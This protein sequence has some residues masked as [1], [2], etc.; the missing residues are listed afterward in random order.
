MLKLR[1]VC[2]YYKAGKNKKAILTDITLDFRDRE[3]V[4]ILGSSGSGKST[5]L[6][7][8]G[9]SLKCDSGEVYLDGDCIS[10]YSDKELDNYRCNV[11]GNIFQDYNLIEYM[12]VWD[13][14]MLGY[15]HG[16]TKYEIDSLLKRLGIY[17]YKHTLV[18]KLSGGEKQ[19]VAI[20][21]AL[22]N[23]PD[24]ILADEPTGAL[25]SVNSTE[26]MEILKS[27]ANKKLVIV[28]S[29]DN[30]LASKYASRI[31]KIKDG[32]CIYEEIPG[33]HMIISNF[34][35]KKNNFKSV[36][37]LS[38]KNLWLKKA[39]TLF[40]SIAISLG[41]ISMSLVVILY[42]NFNKEINDLERSI[43]KVFPITVTNQEYINSDIKEVKSNDK[44]IIK[45]KNKQVY[46][47]KISNKYIDY[48][49]EIK[50]IKYLSYDYDI[51]MPL[52]SD[53]YKFID[54]KYIKII[55][56]ID[57]IYD[58]YIMLAGR[59]ILDKYEILLK[60]DSNNNVSSELLNY[61][62]INSDI[63]YKSIL[64][65]K[66]KVIIN[67]D[68]Y[69]KNNDYY[70]TSDDNNLMYSKSN[71]ELS[72]V[73]IIREK[74]ETDNNN[75]I[76]LDSELIN[77][78]IDINRE[79]NIVK[80]ALLSSHSILG[81]NISNSELL[82]YLGYNTLPRSINI[83]VDN[84]LDK[85]KV[86]NKL[87][88]YNK[89]YNKMIYIDTM[90]EAIDVVRKFIS[91][92]SVILVLFSVIAIIIST[93]MVGILT[94]VRVLERKKEIGIFRSLGASKSDIRRIFNLE[95]IIMLFISLFIAILVINML[96]NPINRL[97]NNYIG[98]ENIFIVRYYLVFLVFI[99]NA[100]IVRVASTIPL[101]RASNMDIVE[102]IYNR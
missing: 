77:N 81:N 57:Y 3:L 67:N 93:L 78:I 4:F 61:F 96:S 88:L 84:L 62:N 85:D 19:R 23:N 86:I 92:I 11:I 37:K 66:I 34:R 41:I 31:I 58:N 65:R 53:S 42:S 50:E 91:I 83:Y 17:S 16:L 99:I 5:L 9:G 70:I 43:V 29:H 10:N 73:G 68:Y 74:E 38:L 15:N 18:S 87:D 24:I 94:N 36:I 30:Y 2:K 60:V 6:N 72:I 82:S 80:D 45:D 20:V 40:T 39:R 1:N 51:S 21:R 52:I 26:V 97:M 90:A 54:N 100:L 7:I 35:E 55:P 46:I 56:S 32:K 69:I 95:N 47:N 22:A 12:S 44:I 28:V 71:I 8:I 49:K 14:I 33:N 75:Y 13:N 25:D 76:Y 59:N 101:R 89:K 64:G 102:C 27:I 48:L 98:I 63:S 79:S